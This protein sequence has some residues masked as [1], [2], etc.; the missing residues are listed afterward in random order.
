MYSRATT[1]AIADRDDLPFEGTFVLGWVLGVGMMLSQGWTL[2]TDSDTV[3]SMAPHLG[4]LLPATS[5][6]TNE[7]FET[8]YEKRE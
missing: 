2:A 4:K 6:T 7:S 3:P 1:S 8:G 5:L